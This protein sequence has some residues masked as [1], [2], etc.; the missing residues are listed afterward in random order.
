[1]KKSLLAVAVLGA[2]AG[3]A[4]A[5]DVQLYGV[6]DT[7]LTY[8]HLDTDVASAKKTNNFEMTSG[9]E[10]GSRWGL[11]GTE[12]LGNG[13]KVG[14]VLETQFTSDNGME[15]SS[16]FFHRQ[17]TI[18][19]SGSFGQVYA[20]RINPMLGGTGTIGKSSMLSA[21]G[22]AWGDYAPQVGSTMRTQST[23]NNALV[24]V[25][26][27]FSGFQAYA[28][29]SMG[30]NDSAENKS[31]D[32]ERY[33]ALAATYQNGPVSAF[34]NVDRT[35]YGHEENRDRSKDVDD[36]LTV[37]LGGNYDFGVLKAYAAVQYF[38]E[39][40]AGFSGVKTTLK[41]DGVSAQ[42]VEGWGLNLS[43]AAPVC[44]GTVMAGA[45]YLDAKQA[46]SVKNKK[47]D[48]NRYRV[49][50][51]YKYPLSKRTDI[52]AV[53]GY[54]KD[55]YKL[56]GENGKTVKPSYATAMFGIKHSF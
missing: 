42:M 31:V 37:T 44:G 29:Y 27:K 36:S 45:S 40:T 19:V 5:A 26:P 20:G 39:V 24:Y 3:T 2:F 12:D 46:D 32:N 22:T 1:M 38:D 18:D 33:A 49:G 43:V 52:Y 25:T 17:A 55:E 41:A 53:A 23:R 15:K 51:G 21:F 14:F 35:F 11:K 47:F 10:A 9:N 8:T 54:G 13:Y 6:V 34:F 28:Y 56:K 4:M 16:T 48:L 30:D 7:G 50:V